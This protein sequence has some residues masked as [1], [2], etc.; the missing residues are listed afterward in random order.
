VW[1]LLADSTPSGRD[2]E[3][4]LGSE[5]QVARRPLGQRE[6]LVSAFRHTPLA[7]PSL[8]GSAQ[9]HVETIDR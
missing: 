2:S 1:R 4:P 7:Y 5:S 6:K 3:W 8:I 9:S